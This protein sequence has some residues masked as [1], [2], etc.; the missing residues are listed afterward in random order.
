MNG[1][2][3]M[4]NG[5]SGGKDNIITTELLK[6]DMSFS[7]ERLE[8][9]SKT[10]WDSKEVPNSWK[11]GLIVKIPKKGDFTIVVIGEELL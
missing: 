6:V 10:I 7:E 9:L 11:Q 2:R 8:D 5:K 1:I 4:K 3:K